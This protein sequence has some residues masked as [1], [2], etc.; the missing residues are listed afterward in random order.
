M[1]RGFESLKVHHMVDVVQL[2]ER[3]VVVLDVASS[4]LVVHPIKII[5]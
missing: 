2:V 3:Q 5:L 1:G 4:S